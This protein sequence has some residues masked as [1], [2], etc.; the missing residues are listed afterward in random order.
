MKAAVLYEPNTPLVIEDLDLMPPRAQEVLVRITSA[1]VCRSDYH[2]MKGE[3]AFPMPVVLGHEGAGVVEEVGDGVTSVRPGDAIALSFVPDCGVCYYCTTG[4]PNLC[5]LGFSARWGLMDGTS[6]LRK[7]DQEVYVFGKVGCFAE[8]AVI[9]ESGCIPLPKG[10][11]LDNASLIGCC[12][13]TGVGAVLHTGQVEPGSTVAVVGCG[14]VGLNCV[15]GARL[16]NAERIVAVDI[17]DTALDIARRLGATHTVNARQEDPVARIKELTGGLGADYTFE[18]YGGTETSL[19]A[20]QAARKGGTVVIVGL[21]PQGDTAPVDLV[22]LTRM[23]KVVK[24]S[25]YGSSRPRVD[26]PRLAQMVLDGRLE[27]DGLV[28]RTYRLSELND[29]YG[30]LEEG[31]PGRGVVVF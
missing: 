20:Y 13:P 19:V 7:G 14:G 26:F 8:Y 5:D 21:A 6:R 10:F 30:D 18:A 27:L 29:A 23:E 31:L 24:G 17:R 15:Q 4:R 9:P 11:P 28:Q 2:I 22:E 25:Y 1:G 12:I 16:V 3:G